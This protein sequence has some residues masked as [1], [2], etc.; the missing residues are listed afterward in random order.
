[1]RK[2]H[3][4]STAAKEVYVDEE[5]ADTA[6]LA[7]HCAAERR[8]F[9]ARQPYTDRYCFALFRRA[10]VDRDEGAWEALYASFGPLV[11]VWARRILD[12]PDSVESAVNAAFARLWR[13][14]S[15]DDF[16]NFPNLE[17]VLG[18]LKR[19]TLC[20]AID[21]RRAQARQALVQSWEAALEQHRLDEPPAPVDLEAY[22]QDQ[23]SQRDLWRIV[24]RHLRDSRE[25]LLVRLSFL[26]GWPPREICRRHPEQFPSPAAVYNL[27]FAICDRL[28]HS[29]ALQQWG[30]EH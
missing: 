22:L 8:R 3:R 24:Q 14:V 16:C 29:P 21:E 5:R 17:H 6:A 27:K 20:A 19:A 15:P 2:L 18:D 28:R 10:L 4:T 9:Q 23:E 11:R 13:S 7:A 26:E 30:R 12:D 1:M 25:E